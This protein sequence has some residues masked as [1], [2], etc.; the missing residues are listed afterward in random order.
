MHS[1]EP[2]SMGIAQGAHSMSPVYFQMEVLDRYL[3]DPRYSFSDF[4]F[5]GRINV[6]E[7]SDSSKPLTSPDHIPSTRFGLAYDTDGSRCLVV[8][9]YH[10]ANFP[11]RHQQY[12][13]SFQIDHECKIASDYLRTSIDALPA[14]HISIYAAFLDEQF[15][16][17]EMTK[18]IC[19]RH[20]FEQTYDQYSSSAR[21]KEFSAFV[22]PTAKYHSQFIQILDKLLSDNLRVAVFRDVI[23]L[24]ENI[25]RRD[26]NIE[27][28]PIGTIR[29]LG[30]WLKVIF[31]GSNEG[32]LANI[33]DPFRKIRRLRQTPAHEIEEDIFDVAFY[34]ES[35]DLITEAYSGIRCLRRLIKTHPKLEDFVLPEWM[36]KT[37]IALY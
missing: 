22:R 12:W 15:I 2:F 20:L 7:N 28:R 11:G 31:P 21:P 14:N 9:I 34:K 19:G 24:E 8:F 4:D 13:K 36:D 5:G 32:M 33:T 35:N 6:V 27:K 17:S 16:I 26:G 1:S 23:P 18:I 30:D 29:L 25:K 37:D 10:L 3:N